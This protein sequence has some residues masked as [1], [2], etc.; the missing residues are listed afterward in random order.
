MSY[1]SNLSFVRKNPI[2]TAV[3]TITLLTGTIF[4]VTKTTLTATVR[5]EK[6]FE[7]TTSS[8]SA[9]YG[10]GSGNLAISGTLVSDRATDIGWSVVASGGNICLTAC[11]HA[12]VVG[13]GSETQGF[14][15]CT[16]TS[17]DDCLCSG[18]N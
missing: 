8:G 13:Y 14:V 7:Y 1:T 6:V 2:T 18:P 11:T 5:N 15:S 16:S 4:T 12:C 17:V 9:I 3:V 10:T